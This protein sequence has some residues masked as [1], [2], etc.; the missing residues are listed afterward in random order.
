VSAV[1]HRA[2]K[3]L[4]GETVREFWESRVAK[5]GSAPF[6]VHDGETA[7]YAQLDAAVNAIANGMRAEGVAAG[8]RVALLLPSDRE[9]MQIEFALQKLG[10]V[11][12]PMISTLTHPEIIYVLDHCEASMLIT[13][14]RGWGVIAEGGGLSTDHELTAY[15]SGGARDG[16]R[17]AAAFES[18]DTSPPPQSGAGPL[19]PMAIMYT[20]G[21]TGKPKGVVQPGAGFATAGRALAER[22]RATAEDNFFCTIPLFHT[23]GWHMLVA[24]AIAVGCRFT[25]IPQFSRREFWNQVRASGGTLGIVMPA[26]LSILMTAPP[27]ERDRDNTLRHLASHVRPTEF[28][29]RFGVDILTTW[30]MTEIS[31]LGTMSEPGAGDHPDKYI[32]KAVPADAEIK[33]VLPDG[34]PAAPM[35]PG[36]LWFRHPHV[37]SSY[38]RDPGATAE[39]LSDGWVRTGD[40]C[41]ADEDAGIYFHG[42]IKHVIKRAGE[43]ISGEEVEAALGSNPDVEEC[44]VVGVPDPIYTE[45]IHATVSLRVGSKVTE[46]EL[47]EWC[48][49][50]LA[51][52]KLPRYLSLTAEE[53]PKLAN[54][55]PDRRAIRDGCEPEKAWDRV[56]TEGGRSR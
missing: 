28:C 23:A 38:Y 31:G 47:V 52:W 34:E 11:M 15:V 54:G 39:G 41:A 45:E 3:G 4:E 18:G 35:E 14:E 26:Q 16:A 44:I 12:V 13:D 48:R 25:L 24:P 56:K 22:Q 37:M 32:G 7:S 53:L 36:E 5:S 2:G 51:D 9:L 46:S 40:L 50:L 55:K 1:G 20:S 29:D 21:S 33:V 6:L 30:A 17:D 8:D 43:N 42:R 27:S 49:E 19:D 10:A